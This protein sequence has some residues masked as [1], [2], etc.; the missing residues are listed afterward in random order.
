MTSDDKYEGDL[1][2]GF[3]SV[4]HRQ[5]DDSFPVIMVQDDI[6]SVSEFDHPLAELRGHF[7]HRAA[8]LRMFA[9]HFHAL[10][11]CLD[12][13]LGGVGALRSQKLMEALHI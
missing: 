2:S 9:E 1:I 11:D 13:A 10:A 6:S 3:A 12:G 8:N 4:A 5:Y 7:F